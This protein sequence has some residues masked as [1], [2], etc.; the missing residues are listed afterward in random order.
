MSQLHKAWTED[1][2]QGNVPLRH[3]LNVSVLL[4]LNVGIFIFPPKCNVYK[5]TSEIFFFFCAASLP[6]FKNN[7]VQNVVVCRDLFFGLCQTIIIWKGTFLVFIVISFR[8]LVAC[9]VKKVLGRSAK[10]TNL[11]K[12]LDKIFF[13][14]SDSDVEYYLLFT[15]FLEN[16]ILFFK[17]CGLQ[18]FW[19]S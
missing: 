8:F 4:L 16:F 13:V 15:L 7:N 9:Q 10:N 6:P 14:L 2:F 18:Q 12:N 17:T 5:M 19:F 11:K 3:L 1:F